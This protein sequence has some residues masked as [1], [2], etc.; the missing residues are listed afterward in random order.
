MTSYIDQN[1]SISIIKYLKNFL[2]SLPK[3]FPEMDFSIPPGSL[4]PPGWEITD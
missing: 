3:K 4:A 2:D 1:I